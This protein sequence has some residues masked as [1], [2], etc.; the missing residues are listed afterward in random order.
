MGTSRRSLATLGRRLGPLGGGDGHSEP[1]SSRARRLL[2]IYG[3]LFPGMLLFFVWAVYPVAQ[4]FV[5]LSLIHISEPTRLE[6][7]SR[8]P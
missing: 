8:M 6:S 1:L 5:M 2:P 3:L 7:K 4:S